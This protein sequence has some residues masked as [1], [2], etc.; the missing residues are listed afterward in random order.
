MEPQL[1]GR[2]NRGLQ[3]WA[4]AYACDSGALA[5]VRE[6]HA[7]CAPPMRPVERSRCS[8]LQVWFPQVKDGEVQLSAQVRNLVY[9][10]KEFG[11]HVCRGTWCLM[12]IRSLR[13]AFP[14]LQLETGTY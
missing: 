13:R 4:V 7:A 3:A 14:S 1:R 6:S 8:A 10:Q 5:Q 12:L 9:A 2:L 11:V